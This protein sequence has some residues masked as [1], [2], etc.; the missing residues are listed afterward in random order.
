MILKG[1]FIS[2]WF[3]VLRW[4]FE[5]INGLI[6]LPMMQQ[7]TLFFQAP[8]WLETWQYKRWSSKY[9]VLKIRTGDM[10]FAPATKT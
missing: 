4:Y 2:G 8:Q 6:M 10:S 5:A 7:S 1:F 3:R 9:F